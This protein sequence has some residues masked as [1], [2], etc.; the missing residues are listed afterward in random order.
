MDHDGWTPPELVPKKATQKR[1]VDTF[2]TA[3]AN[4]VHWVAPHPTF[5][6]YEGKTEGYMMHMSCLL[7]LFRLFAMLDLLIMLDFYGWFGYCL[8][9]VSICIDLALTTPRAK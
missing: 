7:E 9:L 2:F 8:P 1:I 5:L 3:F 6:L 4:L